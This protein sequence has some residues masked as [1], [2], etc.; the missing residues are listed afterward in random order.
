[1]AFTYFSVFK[2]NSSFLRDSWMGESFIITC[3]LRLKTICRVGSKREALDKSRVSI[4]RV[5]IWL[6][7]ADLNV[8][9]VSSV[10]YTMVLTLKFGIWFAVFIQR[11]LTVLEVKSARRH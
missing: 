3:N 10:G 5:S 4:D 9:F 6:K 1:M 11:T 2:S 7:N 8:L